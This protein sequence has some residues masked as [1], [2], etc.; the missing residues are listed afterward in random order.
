MYGIQVKKQ[1]QQNMFNVQK[2]IY[3][4]PALTKP[5]NI[6]SSRAN[7]MDINTQKLRAQT[8]RASTKQSTARSGSR[9]FETPIGSITSLVSTMVQHVEKQEKIQED[10]D[11]IQSEKTLE[12]SSNQDIQTIMN[13]L[14]SIAKDKVHEIL[15]PLIASLLPNS[16][17][18]IH[19]IIFNSILL[20]IFFVNFRIGKMLP[21]C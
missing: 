15:G 11:K 12:N 16:V 8:I 6:Q 2:S 1:K 20:I 4:G 14:Q 13:M 17:K 19:K 10:N 21:P 3:D 5:R 9:R 18:Y 7:R